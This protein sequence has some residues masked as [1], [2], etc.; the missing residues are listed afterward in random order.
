MQN[1]REILLATLLRSNEERECKSNNKKQL[2][3]KCVLTFR[4]SHL[5][6]IIQVVI[7]T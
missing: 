7:N 2:L 3:S 4:Q 6:W 5:N 1:C